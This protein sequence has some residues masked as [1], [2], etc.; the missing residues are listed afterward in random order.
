M[1]VLHQ[2]GQVLWS[3]QTIKVLLKELYPRFLVQ[4]SLET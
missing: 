1:M 4:G 3:N 2:L